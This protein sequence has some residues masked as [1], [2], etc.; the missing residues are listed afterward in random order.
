MRGG[1]NAVQTSLWD[2]EELPGTASIA[3]TLLGPRGKRLSF[4]EGSTKPPTIFRA[5]IFDSNGEK[6]WFGDIE[7]DRDANALLSLSGKLGP[8][9]IL[10]ETDGRFLSKKPAPLFIRHIATVVVEGG[11]LLYSRDLA[12]RVGILKRN[13]REDI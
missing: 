3:E 12:E 13:L 11:N 1:S 6:I 5:D 9:Y 2:E 7:I 4:G 8:L 10:D